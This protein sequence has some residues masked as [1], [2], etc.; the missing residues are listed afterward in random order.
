MEAGEGSPEKCSSGT[1][2]HLQP[3]LR[4][5]VLRGQNQSFS[6]AEED[7]DPENRLST[8]GA[9]GYGTCRAGDTQGKGAQVGNARERV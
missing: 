9:A 5:A 8:D 3:H 4:A 2:P 6:W 1:F 7:P